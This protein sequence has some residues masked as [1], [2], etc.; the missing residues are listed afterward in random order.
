MSQPLT[1]IMKLERDVFCLYSDKNQLLGVRSLL[2]YSCTQALESFTA[3]LQQIKHNAVIA[4]D[5]QGC[6]S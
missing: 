6:L 3:Y 5:H 2:A 1:Y 4:Y